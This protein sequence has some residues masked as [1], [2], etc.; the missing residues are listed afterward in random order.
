MPYL[1]GMMFALAGHG[2]HTFAMGRML[3]RRNA[4]VSWF[5]WRVANRPARKRARRNRKALCL[6]GMGSVLA[7]VISGASIALSRGQSTG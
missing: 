4:V 2:E 7:L 1:D 6:I 5:A 3:N